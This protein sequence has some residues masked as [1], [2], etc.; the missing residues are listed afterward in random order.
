M[1]FTAQVYRSATSSVKRLLY[2]GMYHI[3]TLRDVEGKG[4]H[5]LR[6]RWYEEGF[7]TQRLLA[8]YKQCG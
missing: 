1:A 5:L 6:L 7:V 8:L 4:G 2:Q 3:A